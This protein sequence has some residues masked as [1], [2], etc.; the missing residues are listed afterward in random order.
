MPG[1]GVYLLEVEGAAQV[2][3]NP[4]PV[5]PG[6]EEEVLGRLV[7]LS[8]HGPVMELFQSTAVFVLFP[9]GQDELG[10]DG[11]VGLGWGRDRLEFEAGSGVF[12]VI[13]LDDDLDLGKQ[14]RCGKQKRRSGNGNQT[15]LFHMVLCAWLRGGEYPTV[16]INGK[17]KRFGWVM[18]RQFR[19]RLKL[20]R[21]HDTMRR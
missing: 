18:L 12:G 15:D 5:G 10:L 14:S 7:L 19:G 3:H 20:G 13:V 16:A 17:Y 6:V 8:R 11:G 2:H 9:I 4:S 1:I 21:G